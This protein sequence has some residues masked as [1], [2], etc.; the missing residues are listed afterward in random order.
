MLP[1]LVAD[2][3]W[4]GE[5]GLADRILDVIGSHRH[6][7]AEEGD[8]VV[9]REDVR[10]GEVCHAVQ[11]SAAGG[12]FGWAAR[13]SRHLEMRFRGRAIRAVNRLLVDFLTT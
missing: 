6:R 1:F 12:Q 13:Q 11:R 5:D 9:G 3:V 7:H 2:P 4:V 8:S 10:D